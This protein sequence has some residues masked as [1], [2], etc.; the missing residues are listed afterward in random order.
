MVVTLE[1]KLAKLK[2]RHKKTFMTYD[3]T[4]TDLEEKRAALK[5]ASEVTDAF[6]MGKRVPEPGPESSLLE[7]RHDRMESRATA[8]NFDPAHLATCATVDALTLEAEGLEK[9]LREL[10]EA[11]QN[12]FDSCTE[13]ADVAG[14]LCAFLGVKWDQAGTE[15]K[16]TWPGA[17]IRMIF[18]RMEAKGAVEFPTTVKH[19]CLGISNRSTSAYA[20]LRS[21]LRCLP[22]PRTFANMNRVGEMAPE[23]DIGGL[24]RMLQAAQ[25]SGL[26]NRPGGAVGSL[27][28]D[29]MD[30]QK[31]L[32]ANRADNSVRGFTTAGTEGGSAGD[33]LADQVSQWYWTSTDGRFSFPVGHYY[34]T[35]ED[36][37]KAGARLQHQ[38]VWLLEVVTYLHLLGFR[39]WSIINDSHASNVSFRKAWTTSAGAAD[40]CCE[41]VR[42]E[43]VGDKCATCEGPA[44]ARDEEATQRGTKKKKKHTHP[45]A[46]E[47]VFSVAHPCEP[48]LQ[49]YFLPDIEHLLKCLRNN[50]YGCQWDSK[51]PD[52]ENEGRRL[53]VKVPC[54]GGGEADLELPAHRWHR[55]AWKQI[56]ELHAFDI[57]FHAS[58][59]TAPS[60]TLQ[61]FHLDAW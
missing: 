27:C 35:K 26:F 42:E 46:E 39:T 3:A 7:R 31:G 15:A 45:R 55:A 28:V 20:H 8:D 4:R 29:E 25:A 14:T 53:M 13:L 18:A 49:L 17:F 23:V 32:T 12:Q 50:L 19:G 58:A 11:L 1:A 57:E 44:Q 54:E 37:G 52:G 41:H 38:A 21:L 30:L 48:G 51:K 61:A 34:V 60:L 16:K 47:T 33:H 40:R 56:P 22:S 9:T 2:K 10:E 43:G 24:H 6:T 36:T 59:R 5:A